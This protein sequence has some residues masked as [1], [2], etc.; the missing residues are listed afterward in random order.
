MWLWELIR[1]IFNVQDGERA[2][3]AKRP[4]RKPLGEGRGVGELARR[5]GVT[6]E[7]LNALEAR[8]HE[9]RIPKRRGGSRK[10]LA[11]DKELKDMQRRILR[12][13]LGRLPCHPAA[14]GFRPKQSIVANARPHA[15]KAV[16]VRL[17]IE[18]FF[19]STKA[20]RVRDYFR[21]IGWG[22]EAAEIL[23]RLCT[24]KGGLPQGAPTSPYLSNLVNFRLDTRLAKLAGEVQVQDP[25]TGQ[26]RPPGSVAYTRYADDMTF[27]FDTD[28]PTGIRCLIRSAK[29]VIEEEGYK[30]HQDRKL[31][32]RRRHDAQVVT[33]LVVN[34]APNLSRKKRRWLRA[35]EHHV[36]KG[37][38]AT[39]SP[40][41]L[42][43]WQAFRTM[44]NSQRTSG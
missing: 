36:A 4:K 25:R 14:T 7:R 30:L 3:Q 29:A 10:I 19:E 37:K 24:Y 9:F 20:D 1:D 11:P 31:Q 16:V 21:E 17:D 2:R 27:S 41:Q 13:L 40:P 26:I 44:V 38:P 8:Y 15:G 35:V 43:G 18:N 5:L 32:I 33:G 23:T 6:P 39:L 22:Q 28:D 42:K 12:R 34:V